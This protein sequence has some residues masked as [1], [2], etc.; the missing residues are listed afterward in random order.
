MKINWPLEDLDDPENDLCTI[1]NGKYVDI[2]QSYTGTWWPM[3]DNEH[4]LDHYGNYG[5]PTRKD[6]IEYLENYLLT[7]FQK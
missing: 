6:A 5:L 3:Y 7:Y 4:I 2:V 1:V